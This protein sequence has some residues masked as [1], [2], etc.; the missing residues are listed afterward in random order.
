MATYL[1]LFCILPLITSTFIVAQYNVDTVELSISVKKS[2]FYHSLLLSFD[3]LVFILP[4]K[5]YFGLRITTQ[6]SLS[7]T[8]FK[9]A[10][11]QKLPFHCS[12]R[13]G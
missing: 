12:Y 11:R 13:S 3:G 6:K 10:L 2:L 7:T 9:R 8:F 1:E 5:K 4:E